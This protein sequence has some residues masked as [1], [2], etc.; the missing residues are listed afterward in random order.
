LNREAREE[1]QE[2]QNL[3]E[4]RA[5]RGSILEDLSPALGFKSQ[6]INQ[7]LTLAKMTYGIVC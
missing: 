2:K 5:L 6:P 1:R 3:C 7:T 4:L